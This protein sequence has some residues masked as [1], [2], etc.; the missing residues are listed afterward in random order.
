LQERVTKCLGLVS[1]YN[2]LTVAPGALLKADNAMIRREN[3]V[4]DR[5]GHAT[6]ATLST[7]ITQLLNYSNRVLAHRGSA[8]EYDNGSGTFAAYSGAYSAPSGSKMR[9]IEAF[10][11]L[12]A[13]TSLGVKVF[14]DV[15]GTAGRLAGVPRA[16]DPSYSLTGASGFLA[17][18]FQ[19]AYRAVIAKT[20]ANN[21]VITG[22]P[23]QRLW[24]VNAAGGARNVILTLYLPSESVAG[25]VVKFY[26]SDQVSGTASDTAGDELGLVY[27]YELTSTD[28]SNGY[29]SFTDSVTDDLR[30]ATLYTSP[31]Q[32][33][34]LQA[35]D[36]PPVCKDLAFFKE[37]VLYANTQ[38]KQRLFVNLVGTASLSGKTITLG[39]VTYNFGATEI[40]SG[41]GSPQVLVSATGVAAVDIDLTARSLIRVI[42]RYASNTTVYAYYLTGPSDLPGQ[43]VVEEKGIGASAFTLQAS[44]TAISSMFFPGP[45]VSPATNTKSTSSNSVQKNAVFISKKQ[46]G[47]HVPATNYV[48]I[49]AA[50]KE[51]LRVIALRDSAIV[52]KEE[53][54]WRITGETITSF[55]VV[56]VDDTVLCKAPDSVKKLS[57]QVYM[58]S[59]QGVVAVSENGAQVISR[60][61]APNLTPLLL[62]ANLDDYTSAMGYESEGAYFLSTVSNSSD[63]EANQTLIYNIYTKTWVRHTYAFSCAI[64]EPGVDKMFFAKP[65]AE[66]IYIERKT[67]TDADYADPESS[68]T[69]LSIDGDTVVFTA[70]SVTP[71]EGWTIGQGTTE[72]AIEELTTVVGGFQAV[73]EADA[74]GDWTTG[75]ATLYPS[76]GFDIEWHAFTDGQ[77]DLLKEAYMV[78]VLADDTLSDNSATQVTFTFRTNFDPE[79][80]EVD[81]AQD[82]ASWGSEWGSSPWGG[83]ADPCGYPTYVPMNKHYYNR[84]T[85]GVKHKYARQKLVVAGIAIQGNISSDRIGR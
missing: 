85:C 58:L 47:E 56:S 4:E 49:G 42:N 54:I 73:L 25:D 15:T 50:N 84:M 62:N 31:S 22:Y 39:G 72:L 7:D 67:F 80:E 41:G 16:L 70:A 48:L 19:C 66:T 5:R 68:I 57:N 60:E 28:I 18:N 82:R 65:S 44:D 20:D 83:G 46:Q 9:G 14:S 69:I 30:G 77:P 32:E 8:L 34:I 55:S 43:I 64:V 51:I 27:Q 6:Y 81:R 11:N 75:A 37:H 45:P 76:V 33:G 74:P 24:V 12:M 21:N 63:T 38:T 78:G 53:G 35:N 59:N 23:S 52:I 3:I 79:V 1:Q 40:I 17:N 29:T 10:S 26:R 36:R 13:T 71:S 2:P 61:I